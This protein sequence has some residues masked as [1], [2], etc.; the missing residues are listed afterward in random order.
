MNKKQPTQPNDKAKDSGFDDDGILEWVGDPEDVRQLPDC[1]KEFSD[2]LTP[3]KSLKRFKMTSICSLFFA[4]PTM[5]FPTITTL[6]RIRART[7]IEPF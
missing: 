6:K 1:A 2:S 5:S 3:N 4:T 7:K